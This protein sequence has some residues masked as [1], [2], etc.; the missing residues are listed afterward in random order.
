MLIKRHQQSANWELFM[1]PVEIF[2]LLFITILNLNIVDKTALLFATQSKVS[3]GIDQENFQYWT[4]KYDICWKHLH[5][6]MS[7]S[8]LLPLLE[9]KAHLAPELC[10]AVLSTILPLP[11]T[12]SLE[13]YTLLR[14]KK[15]VLSFPPSSF[16]S[17]S[18]H[19]GRWNPS[20]FYNLFPL[21]CYS[22]VSCRKGFSGGKKVDQ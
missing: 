9:H 11:N 14:E 3:N 8:F 7:T 10:Q 15:T 16:R 18:L 6:L 2:L 17:F 13:E 4:Q 5:L 22:S 12:L 21:C 20:G 1:W 19:N